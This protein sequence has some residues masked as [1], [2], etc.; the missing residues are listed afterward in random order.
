MP[1]VKCP[2]CRERL[3]E[4]AED[5]GEHDLERPME[6]SK[7]VVKDPRLIGNGGSDP[8]MRQLQQ[9]GAAGTEKNGGFA[10]DAPFHRGRTE[11][12]LTCPSRAGANDIK[13]AFK[14]LHGYAHSPTSK[15]SPAWGKTHAITA[16]LEYLIHVVPPVAPGR[17]PAR[18][19]RLSGCRRQPVRAPR[20]SR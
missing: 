13:A 18:P 1:P 2:P 17:A 11:Q 4:R 7:R 12:A 9:Q 5:H 3:I 6:A 8:R 16:A 10:I 19:A 14:V 20:R 15:A